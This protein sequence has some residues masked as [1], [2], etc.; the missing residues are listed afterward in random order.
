MLAQVESSSRA[1]VRELQQLLGF[2]R[3]DGDDPAAGTVPQPTLAEL[4]DLVDRMRT[5]GLAV[6]LRVDGLDGA[7]PPGIELSAYRIVQEALT[8]ALKH[9][10]PGTRTVVR[11]D[12]DRDG[13]RVT[14][15]DDG[16]GRPRPVRTGRP[17]RGLIGIR[18]RAGLHGGA[19]RAGPGP[20]GGYEVRA[21]IPV[22]TIRVGAARRPAGGPGRLPSHPRVG[23][24]PA[25]GRRGRGRRQAVD[26]A[27]A[28]VPDVVLM[29]I[30][31]PGTDGLAATRELLDEGVRTRVLI[32][33][34]FERDEYVFEAL[35]AGATGFLLKNSSPE[36]L[37]LAIRTVSAGRRAALAVG[38]PA[39]DR[40]VRP[41]AGRGRRRV[42]AAGADRAGD[43][44]APAGRRRRQQ[45]RDRRHASTSA[46]RP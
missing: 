14:V 41:A 12:R 23:A 25:G 15:T 2:L 8:N 35:R 18:E 3:R 32:L 28:T 29:D 27:R 17:G 24:G 7:L 6:E 16:R 40:R 11:L 13:L 34:T 45:R 44:G 39:G 21:T 33:T 36:D 1:A 42:G 4:G 10:G 9:A 26:V 22:S 20:D 30:Q 31:M 46:R 5:A 43:R 37:V 19:V 38:D